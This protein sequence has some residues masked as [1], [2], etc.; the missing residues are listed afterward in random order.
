M[1]TVLQRKK[2]VQKGFSKIK[3]PPN[4]SGGTNKKRFYLGSGSAGGARHLGAPMLRRYATTSASP[5]L[6]AYLSAVLPLLQ[7]R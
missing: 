3:P 6:M 1:I 2:S 5:S 7:G 4:N